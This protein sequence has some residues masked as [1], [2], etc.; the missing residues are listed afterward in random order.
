M[1]SAL[2]S[3]AKPSDA[4][5]NIVD[6]AEDRFLAVMGDQP[7]ENPAGHRLGI[8]AAVGDG[9]LGHQSRSC[10][11]SNILTSELSRRRTC[12]R[13]KPIACPDARRGET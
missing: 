8:R 5:R 6:V 9:D 2:P 12:A 3:V 11:V 1:R 13:G 7:V 10:R 4:R